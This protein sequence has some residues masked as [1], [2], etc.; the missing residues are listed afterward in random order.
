MSFQNLK[1]S[2]SV[3]AIAAAFIFP[4]LPQS[5]LAQR[6]IDDTTLLDLFPDDDE[7]DTGL[8]PTDPTVP[9]NK[10]G[11]GPN[12]RPN[13]PGGGNNNNP[14]NGNIQN[15]RNTPARLTMNGAKVAP[16]FSCPLFDNRPHAELIAAIEALDKEVKASPEC[17]DSPSAK[18]LNDNGNTIRDSIATIRSIIESKDAAAINTTKID[19]SMTAAL[20][21]VGNLGEILN[22][23]NFL[24]SKCGR[25]TMSSGKV[26][27]ALN[28]V[29]NGLAPYALF[30]VSMNAA[31]APALPFVAGGIVLTSGISAVAKM[32]DQNTLDM[33]NANHRK[34]LLQNTCQFTK[35]AARVRFMQLAQSGKIETITSE[36]QQNIRLY[37]AQL[38]PKTIELANLLS[39]RANKTQ[40]IVDIEEKYNSNRTELVAIQEQITQN[41]DDLMVCTVGNELVNWAQDGNTFPASVFSGL[42]LATAQGDRSQKLQTVALKAMHLNALKRIS[43][44]APKSSEDEASLKA[45]AQATRSWIAAINQAVTFTYNVTTQ[46]R[47]ELEA[48]LMRN[49]EYQDWK[50][51]Y[52]LVEVEKVTITR[53]EK[54][55]QELAKDNSII[56][57]SELAQRMVRL[58][59]GLFGSRGSWGFGVPPVL[60]WIN[61][62]KRMHDQSAAAFTVDME[63]LRQ[64]ALSLTP[65]GRGEAI[66]FGPYG[67]QQLDH[68]MIDAGRAAAEKLESFNLTNLPLESRAHE[69]ACQQL[70]SA[71][72]DWSSAVDHLGAI[73]FFCD[74][75]DP[76][77]DIKMDENL[78][79]S[80]R[81]NIRL[82]GTVIAKSTVNEAAGVL[83]RKGYKDKA[84]LV[85]A[86]LKSL[87]CPMPSVSVMN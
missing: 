61:H 80:C 31:M 39:Y 56:D 73:Q 82:N 13:P 85:S 43:E 35:V 36:L 70:E 2:A 46:S 24:N 7:Q 62:T 58:K 40:S 18:A 81:G 14:R 23:N 67:Q 5:S 30:A 79:K 29:I 84:M 63:A 52:N 26:L 37:N 50:A 49:P 8:F 47:A 68:Q 77:L 59:S 33:S 19:Q 87:Q 4:Q 51:R 53:V 1:R 76:V 42:E 71:W 65:A 17:T 69:L 38:N 16:E 20:G 44:L 83:V 57:R 60:A 27:L 66:K 55:M 74:L 6:S 3:L 54:A 21:A 15:P 12:Q 78:V 75:I 32:I 10:R 22:N 41:P 25:E 9:P 86:K 72:L 48:E 34:A 64:S 11:Q 28:D 45:C